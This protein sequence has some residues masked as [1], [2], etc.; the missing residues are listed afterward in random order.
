[1]TAPDLDLGAVAPLCVVAV[2]AALMPLLDVL[3]GRTKTF[4]SRPVTAAWA[5]TVM[6]LATTGVWLIA[7]VMCFDAAGAAPRTFNRDHPM[8]LMDGMTSFLNIVILIGS[9]LTALA[10]GKFLAD[11]AINRG[12]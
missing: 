9:L 8:I 4:L 12:E 6:S 1:M 2:G 10:S 7:L 3:L 11:L 5:G